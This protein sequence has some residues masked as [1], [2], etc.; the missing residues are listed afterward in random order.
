M[1]PDAEKVICPECGMQCVYFEGM[2]SLDDEAFG[3]VYQCLGCDAR[4]VEHPAWVDDA[5]TVWADEELY[6]EHGVF[7]EEPTTRAGRMRA[8]IQEVGW[9]IR[10]G[11]QGFWW[12]LCERLPWYTEEDIPF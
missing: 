9:K 6:W 1:I 5:G 4:W 2:G 12:H 3:E 8:F 7:F 11:V 10:E